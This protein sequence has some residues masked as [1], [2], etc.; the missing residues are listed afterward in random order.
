MVYLD[1][2]PASAAVNVAATAFA[3]EFETGT[4]IPLLAAPISTY[5]IFWGKSVAALALG[6]AL[7]WTGQGLLWGLYRPLVG[8]PWP[9]GGGETAALIAIAPLIL[10]PPIAAA[11]LMG[12]RAR[13]VRAAQAG[14]SLVSVPLV[15]GSVFLAIRLRSITLAST[16]T[17]LLAW[18]AIA[19]LLITIGV[20]GWNREELLARLR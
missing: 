2:L 15:I 11:I 5:A 10:L 13:R 4:I 9:L 8:L 1:L 12:S 16:W 14:I 17:E 20:R 3:I 18:A 6:S 7:A 19:A